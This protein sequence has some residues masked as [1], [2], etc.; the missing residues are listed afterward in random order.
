AAIP[1]RTLWKILWP[2]PWQFRLPTPLDPLEIRDHPD[3]VHQRYYVEQNFRRLRSFPLFQL[4]DTPLRS[5]YRLQDCLCA[6]QHAWKRL[7]L[8]SGSLAHPRH[9]RSKGPRSATIRDLGLPLGVHGRCISTTGRSNW[10]SAV[11]DS[12]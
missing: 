2:L 6:D 9:T 1:G 5:L 8:A 12:V 4:R 10:V 11:E 7:F 3:I